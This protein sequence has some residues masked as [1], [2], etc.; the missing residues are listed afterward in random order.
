MHG[1]S[2][3]GNC[4]WKIVLYGIGKIKFYEKEYWEKCKEAKALA[5]AG[6]DAIVPEVKELPTK[7]RGRPPLLGEKLDI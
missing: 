1:M 6:E 3:V 2:N 4:Y 5:K 7:K